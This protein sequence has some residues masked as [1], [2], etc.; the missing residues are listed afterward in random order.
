MQKNLVYP[1]RKLLYTRIIYK[2]K[3]IKRNTATLNGNAIDSHTYK[4]KMRQS[5]KTNRE[6][7]YIYTY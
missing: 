5:E 4:T 2:Q 1:K 6:S 3:Y 7:I